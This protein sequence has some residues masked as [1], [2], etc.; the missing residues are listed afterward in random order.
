MT[1]FDKGIA[2]KPVEDQ[3]KGKMAPEI[4][5]FFQFQALRQVGE[6]VEGKRFYFSSKW[7]TALHRKFPWGALPTIYNLVVVAIFRHQAE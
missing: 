3:G 7:L 2:R 1:F 4:G 6:L 5:I